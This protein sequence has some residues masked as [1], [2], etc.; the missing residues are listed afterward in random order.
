MIKESETV[1]SSVFKWYQ[2][3]SF[4][5][6]FE[7]S[8]YKYTWWSWHPAYPYWSKSCWGGNSVEEAEASYAR[9]LACKMKWYHNK[10]ILEENGQHVEVIDRPSKEMK[11]W[12]EIYEENLKKT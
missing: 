4:K 6:H 9:P 3:P 7:F 10:L 2:V 8:K 5:G 1:D 12:R 11:E